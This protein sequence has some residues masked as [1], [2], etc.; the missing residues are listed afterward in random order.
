MVPNRLSQK[1]W[2]FALR[3]LGFYGVVPFLRKKLHKTPTELA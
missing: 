3:G 1:I 2:D